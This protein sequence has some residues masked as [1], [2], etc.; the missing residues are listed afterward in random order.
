MFTRVENT[1][2]LPPS[3]ILAYLGLLVSAGKSGIIAGPS[4]IG[5]TELLDHLID[6]DK[7]PDHVT[8]TA[9]IDDTSTVGREKREKNRMWMRRSRGQ[10]GEDFE[11]LF[12]AAL[13]TRPDTILVNKMRCQ[14]G[15]DR[16]M[17]DKN[18]SPPRNPVVWSPDGSEYLQDAITRIKA[19]LRGHGLEDEVRVS[20]RTR[21]EVTVVATMDSPGMRH[22]VGTLALNGTLDCWKWIAAFKRNGKRMRLDSAVEIADSNGSHRLIHVCRPGE[23]VPLHGI[24]HRTHHLAKDGRFANIEDLHAEMRTRMPAA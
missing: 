15:E 17:R 16:Y 14:E 20:E 10:D 2:G 23:D 4:G 7:K 18:M 19:T 6:L 22:T 1:T 8:K 24:L 13:G 5:K 3:E 21:K 12:S 11:F 9:V